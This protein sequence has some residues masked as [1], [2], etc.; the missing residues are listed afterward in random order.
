[1]PNLVSAC[2]AETCLCICEVVTPHGVYLLPFLL[3]YFLIFT[4]LRGMQTRSSDE[5]YVCLSVRL[6]VCPSHAWI[7]TKR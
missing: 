2:S 3:F 4:V 7:V 6:S 1:M 5:N